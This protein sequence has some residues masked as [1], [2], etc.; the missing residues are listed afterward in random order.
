VSEP[1]EPLCTLLRQR[2]LDPADPRVELALD[3]FRDASA[4]PER[5]ADEVAA[6]LRWEPRRDGPA[7]RPAHRHLLVVTRAA[8]ADTPEL[9]AAG[10]ALA[11]E[12]AGRASGL[13]RRVVEHIVRLALTGRS[14][15]P[16][17]AGLVA[18]LGRDEVVRRLDQVLGAGAVTRKLA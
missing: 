18:A 9:D 1:R 17:L 12:R 3:L 10:A 4:T 13:G 14:Q 11:L 2:R 16:D 15:G 5:L 6:L 8:L 7:D